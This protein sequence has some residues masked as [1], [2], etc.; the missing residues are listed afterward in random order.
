[1]LLFPDK[2]SIL[3][4]VDVLELKLIFGTTVTFVSADAFENFKMVG[5]VAFLRDI[6]SPAKTV[7]VINRLQ[8]YLEAIYKIYLKR[9]H[10]GE[11]SLKKLH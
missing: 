4:P 8:T 6:Y 2:L 1:M 3:N 5:Q 7:E 9:V 10:Y 11:G